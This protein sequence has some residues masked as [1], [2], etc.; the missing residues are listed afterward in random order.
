M[1]RPTLL[2]IP[3]VRASEEL[4]VVPRHILVERLLMTFD[5]DRRRSIVTRAPETW[6][7]AYEP[8]TDQARDPYCKLD[9][10]WHAA[11][12][13]APELN[14]RSRLPAVSRFSADVSQASNRVWRT[15]VVGRCQHATA[16]DNRGLTD[17]ARAGRDERVEA[18][19]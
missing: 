11:H 12:F 8:E 7:P 15:I 10:T 6:K 17:D 18:L 3:S 9:Q 4:S 1:T 13:I 5:V 16:N 2:T 14:A 19:W